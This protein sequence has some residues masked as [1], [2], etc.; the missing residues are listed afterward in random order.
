MR[1]LLTFS[2]DP[3]KGDTLIKEGRI[4]ETMAPYLKSFSPKQRTSH[5]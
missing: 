2:I 4:G 5:L 3:E 1:V